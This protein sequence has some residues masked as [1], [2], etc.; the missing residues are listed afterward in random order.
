MAC[1]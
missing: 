1:P